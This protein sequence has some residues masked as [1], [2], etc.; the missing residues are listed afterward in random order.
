MNSQTADRT[1]R[2][3]RVLIVTNLKGGVSKTTATLHLA[4]GLAELG[5]KSLVIDFDSTGGATSLLGVPDFGPWPSA[6]EFITGAEDLDCILTDGEEFSL[7]RGVDLIPGSQKLEELDSWLTQKKYVTQQD[8]LLKPLEAVRGKYDYVFIDLPPRVSPATVPSMKVADYVVL[9]GIPEDAAIRYLV[10]T[11]NDVQEARTH[12]LSVEVLGI[13]LT[14]IRKP[15]TRLARSLIGQVEDAEAFRRP[16]GSPLK[17]GTDVSLGVALQESQAVRQTLFQYQPDHIICE[18]YRAIVRE[19]V[20]RI[21]EHE[22]K[23]TLVPEPSKGLPT[24]AAIV[25]E[26][27]LLTEEAGNA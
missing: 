24:P 23:A 6:Y 15:L 11:W 27:E 22:S 17:F 1:P 5:K 21:A 20:V 19:L 14:C 9:C 7:P 26:S 16:D 3:T 13:L 2:D 25:G 10:R 12:G 8:L 18:Q 4:A